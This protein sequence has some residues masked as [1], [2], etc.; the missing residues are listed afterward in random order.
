MVAKATAVSLRVTLT[1]HLSDCH[2]IG[3]SSEQEVMGEMLQRTLKSEYVKN[4]IVKMN[5]NNIAITSI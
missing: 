1:H 2:T 5:Y 3:M 4:C